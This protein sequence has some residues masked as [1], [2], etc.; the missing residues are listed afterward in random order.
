MQRRRREDARLKREEQQHTLEA[1]QKVEEQ[2]DK[3][4]VTRLRE[5]YHDEE[6]CE[7]KAASSRAANSTL[8]FVNSIMQNCKFSKTF[9]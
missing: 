2:H 5:T 4:E 3:K 9:R 8:Q 6:G 7:K 1:Q